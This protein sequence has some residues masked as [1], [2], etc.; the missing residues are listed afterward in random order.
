MAN[1][2][3]KTNAGL[4]SIYSGNSNALQMNINALRSFALIDEHIELHIHLNINPKNSEQAFNG[5]IL[6][7]NPLMRK[8]V[9][10]AFV[11]DALREEAVRAGAD[12]IADDAYIAEIKRGKINFDACVAT[13][14]AVRQLS[15]ISRV[16]GPRGLMPNLKTG[17]IDSNIAAAIKR[18]K[19]GQLTL[20]SDKY[21]IAHALIGST[22]QANEELIANISAVLEVISAKRPMSIKGSYISKVT[23]SSTHGPAVSYK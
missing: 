10:V 23:V 7:P 9:V 13:P 12:H 5:S 19:N 16:L 15:S 8:M 14:I 11:E 22:T 20:K 17:T 4:N 1:T 6:L 2:N 21:G 18:L 3:I